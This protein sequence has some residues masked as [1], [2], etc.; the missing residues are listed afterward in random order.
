MPMHRALVLLAVVLLIPCQSCSLFA[1]STQSVAITA[2]DMSADIYVDGSIVGRGAVTIDMKRN[3][4]HSILARVGDRVAA[5]T[6]GTSISATGVLDI[7]GGVLFLIPLIG[8][9]GPGFW[10]LDAT[11]VTVALPPPQAGN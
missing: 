8:I 6:I 3:K 2:T 7:V 10:E 9:V 11:S 5:T 1:S 4:S